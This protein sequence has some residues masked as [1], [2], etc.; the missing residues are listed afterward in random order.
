MKRITFTLLL[1]V[2]VSITS[3]AQELLDTVAKEVC[4]CVE[5]KKDKL[6]GLTPDKVQA[7]LGLCILSSYTAHDKEVKAK[8]G[9][10][11]GNDKA[12]EKFGEDIGVK[13]VTA[14]PETLMEF[15]GVGDDEVTAEVLSVEGKITEIKNE[16]FT[17]ILVKDKNGRVYSFLVLNYFD[18]ASLIIGNELTKNSSV[19]IEYSEVELYDNKSKEFRFFK[20]ISGI[21]KK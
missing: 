3:S 1:L 17:T 15:A 5:G 18:T 21:E 14:C 11:M 20:V 19:V 13:M 12:M 9:D 10:L 8:Y 4:A 6:Q 16:Q 2:L 7:Q